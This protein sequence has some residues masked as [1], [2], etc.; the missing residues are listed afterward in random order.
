MRD[1]SKAVM[2]TFYYYPDINRFTD[3]DGFLVHDMNL[4]FKTW[5][6]ELWKANKS[7]AI[8]EGND[9][10]CCELVYFGEDEVSILGPKYWEPSI[11]EQDIEN[12]GF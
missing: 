9:G 11:E 2:Y 7:Y 3:E 8:M 12:G 4:Y 10:S 1:P 6:I 5:Q